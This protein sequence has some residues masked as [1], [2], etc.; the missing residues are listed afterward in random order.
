MQFFKGNNPYLKSVV[1]RT[2]ALTVMVTITVSSVITVAAATCN[3]NIN[4]DG[5]KKSVQLFSSDTSDILKEAGIEVGAKDLVV[6]SNAQVSGGDINITVKSAYDVTV[7][8]DSRGKTVTVHYGDT[9]ADAIR[10]SGIAPGANDIVVPSEGTKV[11]DGMQ[12][13]IERKYDIVITADGQTKK[14]VVT[15]GSVEDALREAGIS[16]ESEDIV[17][18]AEETQVSQGIKI[19][20]SRVTYKEVTTTQ[21]IAYTSKSVQDE[22]LYK[23]MKKIQTA[24]K[25]GSQSVVTRQKLVNGAVASSEVVNTSV[26]EPP[27]DQVTLVGTKKK[28]SSAYASF[29]ANGTLTDHDGNVVNYRKSITGRCT[30]YTG[31]GRTSTGRSASFG[32]VAVNPSVIPYGSKLYICSPDGRTVYGYATAADTGGGVMNGR[33]V[34][35]LYYPT[36]SQCRSFGVRNMKIYV[37]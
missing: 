19:T 18:P 17:A 6:R 27:V 20:V 21:E 3:A 11:S 31:G 24:G 25:K 9:V 22:T 30:A 26:L 29:S 32:L 13:N 8:A 2:I 14:A 15:E 23:G 10:E 37:L 7:S 12:I 33:I 5:A 36:S 28:P 4:Y 16:V 34:A 1:K 35:D